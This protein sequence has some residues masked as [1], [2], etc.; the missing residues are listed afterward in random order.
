MLPHDWDAPV[1]APAR[2]V[3]ARCGGELGARLPRR[4]QLYGFAR[5]D[6]GDDVRRDVEWAAAAT[7]PSRPGSVEINAKRDG[8]S[9]W[10]GV[11]TPDFVDVP[12]DSMLDELS[13]RLGWAQ[14]TVELPAGRYETLMP[15][16]TVA[17]MM[18]YLTWTMD[19]RG[20]Q[21]GRTALSAPGGG[22]RVGE[23][24]TDLPLTL[25]SDP[26]RARAGVHA[27]RGG[28]EFVG[29]GFGVRQRDG[30]RAGGLDPRRHDQ[31]AGLP[32]GGG[33]RVRRTGRG[34]RRQPADDRRLGEPGR[35]GRRAPS[36]ACC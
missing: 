30:H 20:A 6:R 22:T 31:R 5:H 17:D 7:T 15:P 33:R 25:Y 1:P 28:A 9:A 8:A 11:S 3:F 4:R 18:I 19:G 36:A 12:T 34:A 29:A 32:A 21:E 24:L 23:K 2:E 26:G 10:A 16:S 14:R 13:T 35:H 27:V